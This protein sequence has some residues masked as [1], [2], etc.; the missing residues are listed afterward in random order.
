MSEQ[1]MDAMGKHHMQ[2]CAMFSAIT[3]LLAKQNREETEHMLRQVV[4][5]CDK[6]GYGSELPRFALNR[7]LPEKDWL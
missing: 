7:L 3:M 6:R 4:E 1:E 5:S 2:I